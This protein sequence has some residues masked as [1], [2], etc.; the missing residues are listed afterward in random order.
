MGL[1]AFST[2]QS[3]SYAP[4]T[5]AQIPNEYRP[6]YKFANEWQKVEEINTVIAAKQ[7]NSQTI[8]A[9]YFRD[10]LKNYAVL[11]QYMPQ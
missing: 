5:Q 9:F 7:R 2:M 8:E 6:N 11:F 1:L 10:L 3:F 4:V